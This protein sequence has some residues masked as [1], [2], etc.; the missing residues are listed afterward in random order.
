M[1]EE[2]SIDSMSAFKAS[3]CWFAGQALFSVLAFIFAV[4]FL[5]SIPLTVFGLLWMKQK[6]DDFKNRKDRK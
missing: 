5:A 6:I 1:T 3:L 2:F 4:A